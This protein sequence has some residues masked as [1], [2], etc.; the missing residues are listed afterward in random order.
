MLLRCSCW[1]SLT[2]V[3][4]MFV[5]IHL[6]T[7]ETSDQS[8][9]TTGRVAAVRGRCSGVQQVAP[10]CAPRSTCFHPSPNPKRYLDR[11]GRFCTVHRRVSLYFTT[12]APPLK[13]A[14]SHGRIGTPIEY[15]VPWAHPS[16]QPKRHLDRFSRVCRAHYCDRP[17]DRARYSV[18]DNRPHLASAAKACNAA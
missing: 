8:N 14:P 9:L 17:T 15:M 12:A 16:L 6:F 4:F 18:Y 10:V 11:F 3:L 2:S 1:A 13:I 5:C 7:G